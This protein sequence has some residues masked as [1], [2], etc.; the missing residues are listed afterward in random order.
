[1]SEYSTCDPAAET[2]I[3]ELENFRKLKRF[4]TIRE[5][6]EFFCVSERTVREWIARGKVKAIKPSQYWLISRVSLI[7]LIQENTNFKN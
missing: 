1:M 3:R 2:I 5:V 7:E 6:A 4:F